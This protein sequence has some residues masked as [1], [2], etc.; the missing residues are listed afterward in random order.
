ME[1]IE[2]NAEADKLAKQ[3]A[4]EHTSKLSIGAGLRKDLTMMVQDNLVDIWT[5]ER[6]Y[7]FGSKET[8]DIEDHFVDNA[9][10]PDDILPQLRGEGED[11][12]EEDEVMDLDGNVISRTRGDKKAILWE[13]D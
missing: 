5:K 12:N 2:R 11:T 10:N 8:A 9:L 7:L 13:G 3:G 1:E 6:D 4:L